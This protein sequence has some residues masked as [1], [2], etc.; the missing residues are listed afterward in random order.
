MHFH[1]T[2]P[3]KPHEYDQEQHNGKVSL[4]EDYPIDPRG[5]SCLILGFTKASL[6]IHIVCGYLFEE[7]FLII[8]LY[9]PDPEQWIDWRTRKEPG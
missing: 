3:W 6:P 1:G 8:T 7:E 9:R 2:F 4:L 5:H